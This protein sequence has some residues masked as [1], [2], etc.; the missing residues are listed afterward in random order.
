MSRPIIKIPLRTVDWI[1]EG[2]ALLMLTFTIIFIF[3]S[4]SGLPDK[5]PTHFNSKGVPDAFGGK[6]T[7]WIV[8]GFNIFVYG[9]LSV[10]SRMPHRF[11]YLIEITEQ[12][13]ERQYQIALDVMR[14]LKIITMFV[15]C[16]IVIRKVMIAEGEAIGLGN[17]FLPIAFVATFIVLSIGIIRMNSK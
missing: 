15:F 4:Y 9:L 13:A 3:N 1:L 5:I 6:S 8:M 12:N 2:V 16:F 17:L 10:A 7:I 11:N 14:G